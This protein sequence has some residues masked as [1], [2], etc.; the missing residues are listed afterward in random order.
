MRGFVVRAV[1][2][3]LLCCCTAVTAVQAQDLTR[4]IREQ[5]QKAKEREA[6]L[7]KLSKQEAR[8][9]RDMQTTE[10]RIRSLEKSI[11]ESEK[12]LAKVEASL[13]ETGERLKR[14]SA[15]TRAVQDDLGRLLATLWPLDIQR[16]SAGVIPPQGWDAASRRYVWTRSLYEKVDAR[17]KEL[18][19]RQAEVE[20][21]LAERQTLA[22]EAR[23]RLEAVNA[24]KKDLLQNKLSYRRKLQ[25]V[26]KSKASAEAELHNVLDVIRSL[27]FRLEKQRGG[28]DIAL[29]KGILPWPADGDVA[30]RYNLKASPPVRGVGLR[31][32]KNAPVKAV[33]W[34]KVM[35]NDVLRGFGRV[36]ILMHGTDYYSLY[37]Y[38]SDSFAEVGENVKQGAVIG[39]AGYYP[40]VNGDG[41]YF[42]LRFHQKAINPE[43]W[44]T[45]VK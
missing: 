43:T 44:L 13:Q 28:R 39:T 41:L 33:A 14:L 2:V 6:R 4:S 32:H 25:T 11:A 16:R 9:S 12:K 29:L 7:K 30:V 10:A 18:A 5:Q 15:D 20:S 17:Q 37:A 26:Q 21:V 45:A 34:G 38:L 35:H 1:L 3:A 27:N 42:E 8:L 40:D 19:R 31:V 36:V 22:D 24:V 23:S